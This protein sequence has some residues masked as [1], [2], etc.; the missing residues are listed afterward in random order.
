[1]A[2]VFPGEEVTPTEVVR[3]E[4]TITA[5]SI[6][7]LRGPAANYHIIGRA[8][9]GATYTVTGRNG[10]SSWWQIDYE[11]EAGWVPA[12]A[13][14]RNEVEAPV[15]S[16]PL[17]PPTADFA[18]DPA[19]GDAPLEVQFMD[20]STGI[21]L[22]WEWDLGEGLPVYEQSPTHT[23]ASAG[24]YTV[25]LRV[26]NEQGFGETTRSVT[27]ESHPM[28][29][30]LPTRMV[31]I[32]RF[33][34]STPDYPAGSFYF[35]N[36]AGLGTN[37]HF[38]TYISS[39]TYEC[40]IISMAALDGDINENGTG[41]IVYAFMAEEGHTWWINADFRTHE[42][43]ETW[44]IGVMC[45]DRS[46][47]GSYEFHRHIHVE[48][49]SNETVALDSL[50]VPEDRTCGVVGIAAWNGDIL[51]RGSDDH[52]LTAFVERN[53]ATG[54]WELT[55]NFLTHNDE[56]EWDVDVLCLYNNPGVLLQRE[57][58]NQIGHRAFN[59]GVSS[60]D[61]VCGVFGMQSAYGDINENGTGSILQAFTYIGADHAWYMMPDFNTNGG[62]EVWDISLLCVRRTSVVA[63]GDWLGNWTD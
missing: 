46:Q 27:V 54:V 49:A 51:E 57:Y 33:P 1:V 38:N 44:S 28:V 60:D 36:Y 39:S 21:P 62:E 25:T 30:V 19:T 7:V 8:E 2:L 6:D 23:Y 63:E 13:A 61:Y 45:L 53:P 12:S 20:H 29:I 35:N 37:V 41:N 3:A 14:S 9:A 50:G 24:T 26:E 16:I 15:A 40:G 32:I 34:T 17:P 11:G 56:E 48:P 18:M 43:H 52:L 42:N 58:D 59:T 55:A 5:A 31:G 4:L 22:R 47:S 10:D